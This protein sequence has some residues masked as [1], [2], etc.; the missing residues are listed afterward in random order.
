M[1]LAL[2]G[3]GIETHLIAPRGRM[4][5]LRRPYR[6]HALTARG[7][8][9]PAA[10]SVLGWLRPLADAALVSRATAVVRSEHLDVLLAHNYEGL[11][12]ALAVRQRC[13]V[14]VVYH[15]HNVLADE[16]PLYAPRR[17]HGF[18]Q[19]IGA[20][21][22]R[23]LP[24][25]A[26]R[27]VALSDDVA[28]HL[29]EVGVERDR[30]AVI[31]PGLDPTPFR[32]PD[33]RRPRPR[34]AVFAGNLD[35]YQNLELLLDAWSRAAALDRG[36]ELRLVTH[37]P[38][39]ALARRLRRDGMASRVHLVEAASL[40]HVATELSSAMVGLS[41]RSSWSGFPIKNLNYMASGIPTVALA[42]SAKGVRH[43]ETG[44]IVQDE[45]AA[46]F[47]TALLSSLGDPAACAR[48]GHAAREMLQE[49]HAWHRL[50]PRL[51][52]VAHAAV[53]AR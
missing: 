44:W 46:G 41:P 22:D 52:A 30:L 1:A 29:V 31:P 34:R 10:S 45:D 12:V 25:R 8:W 47:A 9:S 37:A 38:G 17:L 49:R 6:T 32:A 20:W 19:R 7:S 33:W 21:F 35:G 42:A 24:K 43:D 14:R 51:L 15:S 39:R 53:G 11:L 48:R 28:Q 23:T 3:S 40:A 5:P 16:L 13:G 50:A 18:A 4:R 26:D 36:I 2:H 27:V